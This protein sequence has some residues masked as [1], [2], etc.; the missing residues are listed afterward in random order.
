[1]DAVL[2]QRFFT[3]SDEQL[4]DFKA[5]LDAPPNEKMIALLARKPVWEG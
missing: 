1:M 2:D 4:A 5:A 3:L